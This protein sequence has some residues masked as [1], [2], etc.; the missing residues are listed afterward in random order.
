MD[1]T[2]KQKNKIIKYI[3]DDRPKKLG[4]YIDKHEIELNAIVS[5]KGEKMLHLCAR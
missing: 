1:V 3:I 5:R 4:K 2:S